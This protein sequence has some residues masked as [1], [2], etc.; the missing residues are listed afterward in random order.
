MLERLTKL[1]I[2]DETVAFYNDNPSL[3]GVSSNGCCVFNI[4]HL[5]RKTIYNR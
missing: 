5:W 1:Q 3:R 4:N 2:I